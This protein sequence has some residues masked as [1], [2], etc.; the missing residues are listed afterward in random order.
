VARCSRVTDSLTPPTEPRFVSV[1]RVGRPHGLDGSFFVERASDDPQRFA[2]GAVL[3]VEGQRVEIA[4]SK[5]GSGG[6]PVI[7]LERDVPRG[8]ELT[9]RRDELPPTEEGEYYAFELV[10]LE[11]EEEGGRPLGRVDDVMPG[12]A[13]DV[14]ALDSGAL[15]PLV[16]EC[17]R[18][19]DLDRGRILVAAGF[20]EPPL[21]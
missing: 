16:D 1:G 4:V 17:V 15:L 13:N 2:K 6:R 3:Y 20:V 9:V 10:G 18:A 7:K 5:R 19:I 14:L 11:V 21:P 8:A 12:I